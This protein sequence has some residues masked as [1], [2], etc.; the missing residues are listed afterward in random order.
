[1]GQH[2]AHDRNGGERSATSTKRT[3][4]KKKKIKMTTI[5][6]SDD[7]WTYGSRHPRHGSAVLR[8]SLEVT[9]TMLYR[10]QTVPVETLGNFFDILFVEGRSYGS[11]NR[12]HATRVLARARNGY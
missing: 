4:K 11:T 6:G 10:G 12:P 9:P 1:M 7:Q 5:R 3:T 2:N 8:R